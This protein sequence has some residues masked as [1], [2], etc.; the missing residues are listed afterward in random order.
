MK[1]VT[2][3]SQATLAISFLGLLIGTVEAC[4]L[5]SKIRRRVQIKDFLMW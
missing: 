2:R 5:A 3:L 4:K 1:L